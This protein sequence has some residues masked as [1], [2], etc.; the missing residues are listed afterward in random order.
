MLRNRNGVFCLHQSLCF[1][2]R[3]NGSILVS[4]DHVFFFFLTKR[5]FSNNCPSCLVSGLYWEHCVYPTLGLIGHFRNCKF[6]NDNLIVNW[7]SPKCTSKTL[8]HHKPPELQCVY[9]YSLQVSGTVLNT[10]DGWTTYHPSVYC[11]VWYSLQEKKWGM[12]L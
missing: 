2:F 12:L 4:S 1:S 9:A 8:G 7:K 10:H 5:Y 11:S 3:L 6:K